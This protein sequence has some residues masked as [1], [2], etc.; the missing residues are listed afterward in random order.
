MELDKALF[1]DEFSKKRDLLK[2]SLE[3]IEKENIQF[4]KERKPINK[5]DSHDRLHNHWI[6]F[7]KNGRLKFG[8]KNDSDVPQ[9]IQ[10]R[11]YNAFKDI[12]GL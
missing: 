7:E 10:E 11:S 5:Y 4:F 6:L 3:E 1:G 9:Y 12:F 2:L 8:F